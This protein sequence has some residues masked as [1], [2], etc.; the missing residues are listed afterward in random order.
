MPPEKRKRKAKH[1]AVT[2]RRW[3]RNLLLVAGVLIVL[4]TLAVFIVVR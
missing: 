2:A 3:F 1:D 4:F